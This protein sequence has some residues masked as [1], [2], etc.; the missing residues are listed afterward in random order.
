MTG[1]SAWRKRA[2]KYPI[3]RETNPESIELERQFCHCTLFWQGGGGGGGGGDNCS[4]QFHCPFTL[5][6]E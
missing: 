2:P 4:C 6:C 3:F 1:R 5:I